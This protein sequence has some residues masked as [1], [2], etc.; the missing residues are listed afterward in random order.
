M[1]DNTENTEEAPVVWVEQASIGY[2]RR[3]ILQ[4]ANLKI[5]PG[6]FWIFVGPNGEGKSTLIKAILG[7]IRV[8]KGR[9][10]LSKKLARTRI[11][12]VPQESDLNR[13]MSTTIREF[14]LGGTTG[15]P[16]TKKA[17]TSRLTRVLEIMELIKLQHRSIWHLSLGQ[18]QR[19]M[20]ARAL[21][22]DPLLMIVDEPTAGLDL[23]AATRL[24]NT[25]KDLNENKGITV[26]FVTHDLTIAARHASHIAMFRNGNITAGKTQETLT[27]ENL[28][29]TFGI[30]IDIK[31]DADG[32]FTILR[33]PEPSSET[34]EGKL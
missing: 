25:I 12:F 15:L 20:I 13:S 22:R 14:V 32:N 3:I 29:Q 10:L 16:L 21:I 23:A 30:S 4:N 18:R 24:L 28:K 6:Q 7:A 2:G 19:A 11:G 1:S 8:N 17:R 34:S 31:S 5:F 26:I 27:P 9:V 33:Q